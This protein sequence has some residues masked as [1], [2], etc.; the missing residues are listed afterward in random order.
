MNHML[1]RYA[2]R[3]CANLNPYF[4]KSVHASLSLSRGAEAEALLPAQLL[5]TLHTLLLWPERGKPGSLLVP[6][7]YRLQLPAGRG[8][9]SPARSV[10]GISAPVCIL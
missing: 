9:R 7:Q 3:S 4:P 10:V 1:E 8:D 2:E 5:R 6:T